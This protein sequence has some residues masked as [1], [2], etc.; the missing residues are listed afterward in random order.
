MQKYFD[1]NVPG[2]SVKCKLYCNDPRNIRQM[3]LFGHGLGGHKDNKAAQR[4]AEIM[5]S[6]HKGAA[7]LVFN[8]PCHGDDVKKVL[9]LSDCNAYITIVTRYVREHYG[10]TAPFV[11]ATSFGGYL[12]LNY[13][14]QFGCPFQ[15]LAL[16]CPAIPLY[17]AVSGMVPPQQREKLQKGKEVP[18]GFDRKVNI[19]RSFLEEI[20]A[21]DIRQRDFLDYAEQ[22]LIVQGTKDEIIPFGEVRDFADD[23]LMEFAPIENADHRFQDPALM[24]V[25]IKKILEFFQLN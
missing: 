7:L 11:Y 1:I 14:T 8:W 25:A 9:T 22:I 15:R 20:Q 21:A 18:V 24:G 13:I 16:R 5:L 4:F 23:Q 12:F 19:N 2:H 10:I 6:K 3:V 17:Q